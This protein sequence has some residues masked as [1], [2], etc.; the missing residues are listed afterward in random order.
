MILKIN[1]SRRIV[2]NLISVT[3]NRIPDDPEL[4][5]MLKDHRDLVNAETIMEMAQNR[6]T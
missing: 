3:S 1:I 5:R 2:T 4:M 6:E